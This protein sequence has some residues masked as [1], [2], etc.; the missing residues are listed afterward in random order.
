MLWLFSNST[1]SATRGG[2]YSAYTYT[3]SLKEKQGRNLTAGAD[4][5]R[6]HRGVLLPGLLLL[7]CSACF[8]NGI[9]DHQPRSGATYNGLSPLQSITKY[10]TGFPH[11]SFYL[12]VPLKMGIR[13]KCLSGDP[14]GEETGHTL[15]R[16]WTPNSSCAGWFYISLIKA[17]VVR[18]EGALLR[19]MSP[20]IR[21]GK[22]VGHL[23]TILG[24]AQRDGGK[25]TRV[26]SGSLS[27]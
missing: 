5:E 22:S 17:R 27:P 13:G 21:S 11:P 2:V 19:K 4:A 10:I 1:T 6:G 15:P 24:M 25:K 14:G 8:L 9:Q 12:S 18:E 20:S 26:S 7:V 3:W 16:P 23:E